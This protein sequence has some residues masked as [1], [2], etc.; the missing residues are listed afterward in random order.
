MGEIGPIIVVSLCLIRIGI[1]LL[2]TFLLT[3]LIDRFLTKRSARIGD[4]EAQ[5]TAEAVPLFVPCWEMKDCPT[6]K[7][8]ACQ[9]M[10]RPGVPCWLTMQLVNGHLSS[11]CLD[12]P[13][14][15]HTHV[16]TQDSPVSRSGS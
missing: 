16:L 2:A 6:E 13:V 3:Y 10:H 9:V 8:A 1:P 15:H 4:A 14:F 12:C 11:E 7:R 5:D